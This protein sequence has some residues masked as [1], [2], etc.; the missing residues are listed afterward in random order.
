M[1]KGTLV[2]L[3]DLTPEVFPL[4][5]ICP[6]PSIKNWDETEFD[7]DKLGKAAQIWKAIISK[8]EPKSSK[9]VKKIYKESIFDQTEIIHDVV[10]EYMDGLKT[11]KQSIMEI[12]KE[13]PVSPDIGKKL[14][15]LLRIEIFSNFRRL[16]HV[17][18]S[19]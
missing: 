16:S 18:C 7:N 13:E 6:Y 3:T 19:F 9:D 11:V 17:F 2:D 8:N 12:G 15:F 5:S 1:D 14:Y 4:F 10:V